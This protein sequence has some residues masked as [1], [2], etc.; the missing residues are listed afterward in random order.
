MGLGLT[1]DF[2][3]TGEEC[4]QCGKELAFTEEIFFVEMV[5]PHGTAKAMECVAVRADEEDG[6][7]AYEPRVFHADCWTRM[8]ETVHELVEEMPPVEDH[9]SPFACHMCQSGIRSWEEVCA[10]CFGELHLSKRAPRGQYG[11]ALVPTGRL[12]LLCLHCL[13]LLGENWL[14]LWDALEKECSHCLHRRCHRARSCSCAC[15]RQ[16]KRN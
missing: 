11:P 15:H 9:E 10:V 7:Y 12:D 16:K 1:E 14:F 2:K 5:Q 6:D 4:K 13:Y 3:P 8:V